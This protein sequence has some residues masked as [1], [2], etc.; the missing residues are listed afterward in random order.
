LIVLQ[1]LSGSCDMSGPPLAVDL[2]VAVDKQIVAPREWMTIT[3][4]VQNPE[5]T[6]APGT[7]APGHEARFGMGW[8]F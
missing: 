4:T 8:Q 7:P 1:I 2:T 3:I 5:R 6:R